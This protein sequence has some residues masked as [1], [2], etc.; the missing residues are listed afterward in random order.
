M[1]GFLLTTLITALSLLVAD[2]LLP[3]FVIATFPAAVLAAIAV[4][5][6]NS[7]IKPVL[8]ILTLPINILTLGAFSLVLNGLCF[9]LAAL[10]VPGFGVHGLLAFI[11]GPIV[12]SLA[13][14]FLNKYFVEKGIGQRAVEG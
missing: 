1:V 6:V 12:V 10:V 11:V 14:T 5:V 3:G 2:I 13:S 4:G 9:W 7:F 8:S